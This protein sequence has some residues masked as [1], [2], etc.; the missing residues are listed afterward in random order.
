MEH[1]AREGEEIQAFA[2]LMQPFIVC[3]QSPEARGQCQIALHNPPSGRQ[4]EAAL[5]HSQLDN[6]Q[7]AA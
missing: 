4:D 5:G 2:S 6:D 1:E 3:G 7:V